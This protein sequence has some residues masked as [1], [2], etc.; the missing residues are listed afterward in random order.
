M[1]TVTVPTRA[2][3]LNAL[4]KQ[5]HRRNVVLESADGERFVLASIADWEGFDVGNSSDFAAEVRLTARNKKLAQR[6][7]DRRKE[8]KSHPRVSVEQVRRELGIE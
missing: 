5:T 7:A 8:D 4:L 6:M 1:K 3:T 2:R